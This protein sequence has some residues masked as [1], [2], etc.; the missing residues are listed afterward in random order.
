MV[1]K[2]TGPRHCFEKFLIY[3]SL[4]QEREEQVKR[5]VAKMRQ[6]EIESE[7]GEGEE[8]APEGA[9][10]VKSRTR[11]DPTGRQRI[12]GSMSAPEKV[13]SPGVLGV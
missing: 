7:L 12:F 3:S 11:R 13:S 10:A 2:R 6:S 8:E 9:G 4:L 1:Q 5:I